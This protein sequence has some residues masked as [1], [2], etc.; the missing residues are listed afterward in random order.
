MRNIASKAPNV[1]AYYVHSGTY[2]VVENPK[3]F[4]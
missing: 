2:D 1:S 4:F 3:E